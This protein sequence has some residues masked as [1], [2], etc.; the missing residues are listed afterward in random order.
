MQGIFKTAGTL[1]HCC[2]QDFKLSG[3]AV[4]RWETAE[5]QR[6]K[7]FMFYSIFLLFS[8]IVARGNPRHLTLCDSL[9]TMVYPFRK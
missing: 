7:F 3:T 6:F 4:S 1:Y 9:V 2:H 5:L 8:L